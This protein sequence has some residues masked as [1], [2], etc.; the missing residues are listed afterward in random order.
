MNDEDFMNELQELTNTMSQEFSAS[1]VQSVKSSNSNHESDK[2]KDFD[3]N[4]MGS[5]G[6]YLKEIEKMFAG[7][8]KFDVD[9]SDPQAKEMMKLLSK[10]IFSL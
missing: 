3:M 4:F 6:D 8:M 10:I 5:E 1:K 7:Q 9:E 2:L